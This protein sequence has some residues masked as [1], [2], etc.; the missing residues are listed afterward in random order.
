[1]QVK[2]QNDTD[3]L[4]KA[5]E[6]VYKAGFYEGTMLIGE[7]AG[8]KVMDAKPK[9]RQLLIDQG[10]SCVHHD[11]SGL[12]IFANIILISFDQCDARAYF[13]GR[14]IEGEWLKNELG[15]MYATLRQY[16]QRPRGCVLGAGEGC[17]VAVGRQV[18][19][20]PLRPM[21]MLNSL[22]A[23]RIPQRAPKNQ[24]TQYVVDSQLCKSLDL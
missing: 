11:P 7:Y 4:A 17:H 6:V 14:S 23:D 2:S 8:M 24:P 22:D 3:A 9:T 16:M 13:G 5:K 18:R 10:M 1:V 12:R 15:D 19:R 20:G 21:G